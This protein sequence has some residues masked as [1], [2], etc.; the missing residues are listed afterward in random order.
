MHRL[1]QN[2]V[3]E[4]IEWQL[5]RIKAFE[6]IVCK[7]T[8]G[9]KKPVS[10]TVLQAT[11]ENENQKTQDTVAFTITSKAIF[12]LQS[13]A[14]KDKVKVGEKV[15]YTIEVANN[16]AGKGLLEFYHYL[17]D[18]M[19]FVK[20][21]NLRKAY[22]QYRHRLYFASSL[23]PEKTKTYQIV[24]R[25]KKEGRADSLTYGIQSVG[26]KILPIISRTTVNVHPLKKSTVTA[27]GGS[28]K[29]VMN[30]VL[31]SNNVWWP[32][33]NIDLVTT[34]KNVGDGIAE[35]VDLQGSL[36][37][38]I[39][40]ISSSLKGKHSP[41]DEDYGGDLKWRFAQI[42]PGEEIT[43]KVFAYAHIWLRSGYVVI[44]K[45]NNKSIKTFIPIRVSD[46][47]SQNLSTYDTHSPVY[48]GQQTVYVIAAR[49][50]GIHR[51]TN[52]EI[53]CDL[54][55][56]MQFVKAEGPTNSFFNRDSHQV[57]F[58]RVALLHPGDKLTY[59]I[60]CRAVKSGSA[61]HITYW[62]FDQRDTVIE[63][64]EITIVH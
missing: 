56:E 40:Y 44:A 27:T 26:H 61:K 33:G 48:V 8:I 52:T 20:V 31:K 57:C 39:T 2:G 38:K 5:N 54:P 58:A 11:F 62:K 34:I 24:C 7:I 32:H 9:V 30:T 16:G 13:H 41:R 60:V 37:G 23:L 35:N 15:T 21:D 3:L 19:E 29:L 25:A 46:A 45:V 47:S 53:Y 17:P 12:S 22:D 18:N 36:F 42:F 50:D 10:H 59:K 63:D 14:N 43:I 6:K 55:Q 51:V 28:A 1:K 4:K 64:K 49:N